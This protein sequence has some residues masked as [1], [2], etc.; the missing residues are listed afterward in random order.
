MN[1]KINSSYKVI[2]D[3]LRSMSFLIADGVLPANEGR[4]YVLRRI[5]RRAMLHS[6]KLNSKESFIH[7]LTPALIAKMGGAFPELKRAQDLISAT[8]KDEEERFRKTLDRGIE[9]LEEELQKNKGNKFS[10][11]IAF[12][13]YD[14]YG[15]PLDLTQ[16]ILKEKNIEVDLKEF[17]EEMEIQ[18][19]RAKKNWSGSG[20]KQD[21]SIYFELREKYGQTKF[22][23]YETTKSQAKILSLIVDGKEVEKATQDDKNIEI[24]LDQTPFYGTSGGQRGDEG[25]IEIL[26]SKGKANSIKIKE[27]KKVADS[28]FI[29]L[30]DENLK[31]SKI[32]LKVGDK[33]EAI[34]NN[35]ETKAR[36]HSVTHLLH[37]VLKQN[38]GNQI[39]QKGSNIESAYLTFDFN[40]NK[41][42]S[43]EELREIEDDVNELIFNNSEV[44]TQI[45]PIN[46]AKEKGAM[47]LFGEKYDNVVRVL[48]MGKNDVS[49]ELCGGTHVKKT[50][51]IGL[52]KIISEKGIAAGIR[53]ITAQ[54]GHKAIETIRQNELEL[55]ELIQD[56][57]NKIKQKN[58]EIEKLKKEKLSGNS[59]EF[60]SQKIGEINLISNLFEDL[61]AKD[62]RDLIIQIKSKKEN[63][64]NTVILFFSSFEDKISVSLSLSKDLS[65]KFNAGKLIQTM[66]EEIGGKGGGGKIDLAFGGGNNKNGIKNAVEKLKN[67]LRDC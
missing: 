42:I 44:R 66:V 48:T 9:I 27:T 45:M 3:H 11:K 51:D 24:I 21:D 29:H 23:G 40:H 34:V 65:N 59:S 67:Y 50:G 18:K 56:L 1:N 46:Q 49:V 6:H 12:K 61:E 36:N 10:G 4:G 8:I 5:M 63:E 39:T 57:Q 62:L 28:V 47:A 25:F 20:E 33:V 60:E 41:P 19:N 26:S 64:A 43:D 14:T 13:L 52:F 31:D 17:E 54:T 22:L 53:R 2:A 58:K 37:Y 15:F 32:E 30:V 38:L 16:N 55:N 7:K 35:R